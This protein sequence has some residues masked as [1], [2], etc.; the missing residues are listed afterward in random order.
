MAEGILGKVSSRGQ[1]T[2]PKSL[3]ELL[4]IKGG[5]HI[6][7]QTVA[8]G[9]LITKA[10]APPKPLHK[11]EEAT[12]ETRKKLRVFAQRMD[13]SKDMLTTLREAREEA[14]RAIEANQVWVNQVMAGS[15]GTRGQQPQ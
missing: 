12:S 2:I 9:V 14:R 8:G 3:R 13:H 11:R 4:Q 15:T 6:L 5:D 1:I 10:S 7:W